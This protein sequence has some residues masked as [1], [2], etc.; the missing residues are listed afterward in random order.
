[1]L[2]GVQSLWSVWISMGHL[3]SRLNCK[4]NESYIISYPIV[5]PQLCLIRSP[6]TENN[7]FVIIFNSSLSQTHD[8]PTDNYILHPSPN[9]YHHLVYFLLNNNKRLGTGTEGVH[10]CNDSLAQ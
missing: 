2:N 7:Q 3:Q 8:H 5:Y 10:T 4:P 6:A 9:I 1:M